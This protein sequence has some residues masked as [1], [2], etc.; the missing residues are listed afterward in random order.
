MYNL[1]EARLDDK[2]WNSDISMQKAYWIVLSQSCCIYLQLANSLVVIFDL[3]P[4]FFHFVYFID[5]LH[6]KLL[7]NI[8]HSPMSFFDTT[9][10]GRIVNRFS[11]D[12]DVIDETLPRATSDF[13]W[14]FFEVL[15]MIVAISYATPLYLAVLPPL[16][17]LYFYIQV[18]TLRTL[19]AVSRKFEVLEFVVLKFKWYR[20]QETNWKGSAMC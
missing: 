12:I 7:T 14:C 9:P 5:R 20:F 16:G 19:A 1:T 10:V 3:K 2:T 13:L 18:R 8:M 17:V 11:K 6:D 15:G 4:Q